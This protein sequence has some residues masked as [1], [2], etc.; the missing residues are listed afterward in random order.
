METAAETAT[1][2]RNGLFVIISIKYV[3][4]SD[5]VIQHWLD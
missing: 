3:R 4:Y 1:G 2:I 5:L